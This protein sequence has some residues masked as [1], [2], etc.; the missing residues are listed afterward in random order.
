MICALMKTMSPSAIIIG[1]MVAIFSQSL[2]LELFVSILGKNFIGFIAGAMFAMTW[3]LFHKIMNFIIYYGFNIVNVY[4]DLLKY[5]QK[6]LNIHVD[7][8]W[9]PILIL[10]LIYCLLGFI[11]AI[12]GMRVG[13][14]LLTQASGNRLITAKPDN[15]IFSNN[16]KS[17]NYS[18]SWLFIDIAFVITAF[19]LLNFGKW[20]VWSS[21]I[22]VIV[23][24]WIF[25]YKRALRQLSRP[26]FW[27]YFVLI[28][29]G[30][31]FVVSKI[32]SQSLMNGLEIGIQMNFRAAIVILGFS[33][34]GTELYNPKVRDFFVKTAFKQLPLALE[35]S[36]ESLPIMISSVPEFKAILR[37][38]V[39]VIYLVISQIEQRLDEVNK[40]LSK[41]IYI[42]TGSIGQGKTTQSQKLVEALKSKNISVCGICSPRIIEDGHTVGYDIVDINTSKRVPFLRIDSYDDFKKIGR[43][44]IYQQA[45]ES[46]KETLA[47]ASKSNTDVIVVDEIGKMELDNEGWFEHITKLIN[48]RAIVV[49]S[50]RDTFVDQIIEKWEMKNYSVNM[51]S[52]NLYQELQVKIEEQINHQ[53]PAS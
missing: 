51:V 40:K 31:S 50:V 16:K 29:M 25:R 35:L 22:L 13:H 38:P 20:L 4:T 23:M 33:V 37:D 9:S 52:G 30:T 53:K 45:I 44:S 36:F 15:P 10:I 12:V 8:V 19:I 34:L 7:L 42:I 21:A 11:S 46:G 3:N 28:T 5:A 26:R 14:R 18:V 32:Q 6:Q 2:L 49:F 41:H 1:P 47:K 27:I 24:I 43:Y 39:S 48:S 17:F